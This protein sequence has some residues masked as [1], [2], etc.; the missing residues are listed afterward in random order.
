MVADV[1]YLKIKKMEMMTE[2]GLLAGW[3]GCH[4]RGY[5][6]AWKKTGKRRREKQKDKKSN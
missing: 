5:F 2:C 6:E 3:A 4:E 1:L